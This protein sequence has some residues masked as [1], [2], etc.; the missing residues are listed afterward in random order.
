M[1]HALGSAACYR[2]DA[3]ININNNF[4]RNYM[5]NYMA[6][7]CL[8]KERKLRSGGFAARHPAG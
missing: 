7:T 6:I 5:D 3:R 2:R 8:K 4:M 1:T